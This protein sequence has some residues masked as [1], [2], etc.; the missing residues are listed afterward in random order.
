MQI[1]KCQTFAI[2]KPIDLSF[3]GN[4][5]NEN[6]KYPNTTISVLWRLVCVFFSKK[7]QHISR[8]DR[9]I[10]INKICTYWLKSAY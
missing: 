2:Y 8:F 4:N 10:I 1:F 5:G 6:E 9:V 7:G 3:N